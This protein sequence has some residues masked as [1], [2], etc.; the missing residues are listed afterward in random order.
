MHTLYKMADSTTIACLTF[1]VLF[2]NI[3]Y[4]IS[5]YVTVIFNDFINIFPFFH[6]VFVNEPKALILGTLAY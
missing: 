6:T 5:D 2:L 3:F 4:K 1:I